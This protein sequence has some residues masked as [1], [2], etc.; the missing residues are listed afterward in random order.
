MFRDRTN[1]YISYRQSYAHHPQYSTGISGTGTELPE[2][3][4]YLIPPNNDDGD[5]I[6]DTLAIEMDILPPTWLDKSDEVDELLENI[7][8]KIS[9]LALLHKKNALPGF[10]DR[11]IEEQQIEQLTYEVTSLLHK[12]QSL[13]KN[14][15]VTA[16]STS[17]T[18]SE[19]KMAKNMTI[20]LATKVQAVS[21]DFRK[22]QSN[23]LRSLKN[24]AFAENSSAGPNSNIFI[25]EP[26]FSDDN[27]LDNSFVQR[28]VM[29]SSGFSQ[30]SQIHQREKE[31]TTIAQ[32]ILELSAIF[33]DL[34]TMVIDQGTILDRIDYNIETT[35]TNVKSADKELLTATHYQKRTQ[36]CKIILLLTLIVFGLL[37]IVIIKPKR[38]SHSSPNESSSNNTNVGTSRKR[39]PLH[40][41]Y[42]HNDFTIFDI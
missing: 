30:E 8:S 20:S 3:Q 16:D 31:I 21:T 15:E 10:D 1:L 18:S 7:R 11:A 40:N 37:I 32:G 29:E 17:A 25:D 4:Q 27:E 19:I 35:H 14:F 38:H 42:S 34:Q 36:K 33:K 24:E 23:Y 9:R 39:S 28:Q 5:F 6:P 22:M 12:C 41:S 13:I 2:E 26:I